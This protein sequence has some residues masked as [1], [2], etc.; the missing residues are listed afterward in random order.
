MK[1]L[2]YVTG[3]NI[4]FRQAS[5]VSEPFGITLQQAKVDVHEIQAETGEPIA[6]DKAAKAFEILNKPLVVSDDNW[7]IPG[8]KNFPGPYMRYMNEWFSSEDWLRLTASLKDRRV[9][10]QQIVVYQDAN[11]QRAFSVDISGILLYE[12]RGISPYPH[13]TIM[14]FDGGKH[15]NAEYHE[16]GES[17]SQHHHNVWRDFAEWYAKEHATAPAN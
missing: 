2:L 8:L 13:A 9:I 4:K 14:S 16:K 12:I 17:A 11:G 5:R 7:M 10:L 3:N 15:S 1:E 6:R